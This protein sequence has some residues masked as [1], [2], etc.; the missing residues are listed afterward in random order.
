MP[1]VFVNRRA[2]GTLTRE[3]PV[4]RFVYDDEVPEALAVSPYVTAMPT[5]RIS[6]SSTMMLPA[7]SPSRR[8]LMS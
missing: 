4:N 7:S 1:K 8:H 6:E 2:V 3:E 5:A